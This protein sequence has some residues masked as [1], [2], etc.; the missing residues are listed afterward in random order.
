M[1]KIAIIVFV[2]N[3]QHLIQQFFGL[4]YSVMLH[5]RLRSEVD[6]VIG[7]SVEISDIF[8]LDNCVLAHTRE[9][10]NDP[11]FKFAY[12]NNEYGYIN[13]WSHFTDSESI[14]LILSY[15]YALRIDVDTFLSPKILDIE[16]AADEI[17][18]GNGGYIGEEQTKKNLLRLA[19]EQSLV[20]RAKHNLGST[21]YTH[22]NIMVEV[23]LAALDCAK[24]IIDHEFT[25]DEGEWPK[26]YAGVTTMYAGELAL[27]NTAYSITKSNKFDANSTNASSINDVF[28]IHSWHTDE[29][30]SKHAFHAGKYD[31][32]THTSNFE[33]IHNYS[34]LCAHT[35]K[36]LA[37]AAQKLPTPI[38]FSGRGL[39][40][41]EEVSLTPIQAIR[42]AANLLKQALPLAPRYTVQRLRQ[43]LSKYFNS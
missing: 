3:K 21:W 5:P 7:C 1:K 34:F 38:D 4:Y 17:L 20:H 40:K 15:T 36:L 12:S 2:P 18:V 33:C 32:R 25:K 28:T 27:N 19:E 41:N 8:Q 37:E 23:G 10:S 24:Y 14:D 31:L 11:E 22:S 6:F 29:F 13:S 39:L 26:W 43:E 9:I 35:G 16:L 30:F 42:M